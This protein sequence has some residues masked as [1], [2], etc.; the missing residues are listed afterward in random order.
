MFYSKARPLY[1]LCDRIILDR[2]DKEHYKKHIN[3]LSQKKWG[4]IFSPNSFEALITLTERHPFYMNSLCLKLWESNLKGLPTAIDIKNSWYKLITEERQEIAKELSMLSPSQRKILLA[5][6]R[7][8]NKELTG[9]EMIKSMNLSGASISKALKLLIQL[10]YVEKLENGEY[11][12]IDP[13]ISSALKLYFDDEN[14]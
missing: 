2:I 1:K 10:D 11:H 9:K 12:L 8:T 6:S 7:G 14:E 5:I 4:K 13:L 3:K